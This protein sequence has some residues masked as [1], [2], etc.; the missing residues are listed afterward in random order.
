M[1]LVRDIALVVAFERYRPS[2]PGGGGRDY[3]KRSSEGS[4]VNREAHTDSGL[5]FETKILSASGRGGTFFLTSLFIELIDDSFR[6]TLKVIPNGPDPLRQ[7]RDVNP[8]SN[9][10]STGGIL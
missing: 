9:R 10:L 3:G 8:A 2:K 5:D 7:H 1:V 4:R 6:L